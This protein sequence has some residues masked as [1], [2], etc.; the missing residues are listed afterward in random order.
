MWWGKKY[1]KSF[2][3]YEKSDPELFEIYGRVALTG[4][5][6]RFE[7]Y[8]EALKMWFSISV[9]SPQKEHFVAI[10]DVITERKQAE[11]A[12]RENEERFRHI[13][14]NISDISYSCATAHGG[15]Y[16]IDWM[17]G[18]ADSITGYSVEE[19]KAQRC[20]RFLV[21]EEDL[22]L[23]DKHVNGLA[24]GSS[25]AC[26]LRLRHK[27]GGIV[28]VSSFAECVK[29]SE[30]PERN[31]LYGGLVDITERKRAEEA[32]RQ[33]EEKY[34]HIFENAVEGIFQSTP[35]GRYIS[36]NPAM[37]RMFGYESPEELMAEITD[38]KTQIYVD[39][40]R[41]AEFQRLMAR[42]GFVKDFEYQIYRKD[43]GVLWLSENARA[44]RD[45]KGDILYYE[46]F[47]Q[48]I[49]ERK[50]AETELARLR[51]H[52]ELILNSAWEG[53]LGLDL[54]GHITFVNPAAAKAFGYEAG[55]LL[56]HDSHSIWHHS[57]PDGSPY[58]V[59][60]CP[61]LHGSSKG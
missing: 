4:K 31:R 38:I 51:R 42:D 55:E 49:S 23:F 19:I 22:S 3:A 57:K 7:T 9:Y 5:P 24:P 53:I 36:A 18:A 1:L 47:M 40:Q 2:R 12:L 13:S 52:Q 43:G 45:D 34:R 33:A 26:E 21:I 30:Q 11:E 48:D 27:N 14:S 61:I 15:I 20:W 37:A 60:E 17:A 50:E 16:E 28:W 46:G 44:V 25:V 6:E 41:R 8:V 10:F 35:E 56:G 59:E 39:P 32:L 58:P 29:I 54:N